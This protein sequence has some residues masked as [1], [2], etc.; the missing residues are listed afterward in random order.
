[1]VLTPKL[2]RGVEA[3]VTPNL[4][5]EILLSGGEIRQSRPGLICPWPN[6]RSQGIFAENFVVKTKFLIVSRFNYK[7]DTTN[8]L[9]PT[10]KN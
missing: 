9:N 2:K 4:P 10:Y 6:N 5:I 8:L 3:A 1:M 7:N